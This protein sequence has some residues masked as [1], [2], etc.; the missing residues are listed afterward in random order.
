MF[1]ISLKCFICTPRALFPCVQKVVEC[2]RRKSSTELKCGKI[3]FVHKTNFVQFAI[4]VLKNHKKLLCERGESF[5]IY[6]MIFRYQTVWAHK[7]YIFVNREKNFFLHFS[8]YTLFATLLKLSHL[9]QNALRKLFLKL[10][11]NFTQRKWEFYDN[12][13]KM[14]TTQWANLVEKAA[15]RS[16]R[17]DWILNT[18]MNFPIEIP[19]NEWWA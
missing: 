18:D 1:W 19:L 10:W 6:L 12:F 5:A 9:K 14:F 11:F 17:S 13:A 8:S 2:E 7:K 15:T 16:E 4:S 3:Y